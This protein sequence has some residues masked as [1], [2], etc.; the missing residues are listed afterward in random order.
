[1]KRIIIAAL[2]V[3]ALSLTP[4]VSLAESAFDPS[5]LIDWYNESDLWVSVENGHWSSD[6]ADKPTHE[7]LEKMFSMAMKQQSA[8]SR[9]EW[10]F[11]AVEDVEEQRK[12]L[13]DQVAPPEDMATEGTVTILVMAD[14]LLT[15]EEGHV[16]PY[17]NG[18]YGWSY[19][20]RYD[21]GMAC[22]LLEMAAASLGYY[23]HYCGAI[24]GEYAQVDLPNDTPPKFG[25][26]SMN[27]YVKE[28]Y[29]RALSWYNHYGTEPD[30]EW[31]YPVSG[32]CI[33]VCAIVVGK[34]VKDE[35]VETWGS[36][37]GRPDNWAIWDGVPNENPTPSIAAREAYA[38]E[39]AAEAE[40]EETDIEL[41][42]NEYLGVA[43]GNNGPIKVKVTVVDGAITDV[44]IVEHSE[45]EGVAD[46]AINTLPAAIVEAQSVDVDGIAGATMASDAIK[47][48]VRSALEQA[49][50]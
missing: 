19:Q 44:N 39:H 12:I 40:A 14:H 48:A 33:F 15:E 43:Q 22:G 26:Q 30:D 35:S 13:G 7:D 27:R 10:F 25:W 47:A 42:E 29:K 31:V 34:P 17:G 32:N 21:A 18:Y 1:M 38:A 23:T 2:L 41:G 49:G 9:T 4:I 16:S 5:G 37:H 45:T 8:G 11:I 24:N 28:D 50:K 6:P 3:L 46:E 20:A 36:L